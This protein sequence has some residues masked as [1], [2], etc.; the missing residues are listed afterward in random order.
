M[1]D[2]TK[3][4]ND[5]VI[6][7]LNRDDVFVC[8]KK[9]QTPHRFKYKIDIRIIIENGDLFSPILLGVNKSELRRALMNYLPL[10]YGDVELHNEFIF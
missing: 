3:I 8:V 5:F 1:N 10:C 7:Y 2:L 6:Y 9:I 4:I